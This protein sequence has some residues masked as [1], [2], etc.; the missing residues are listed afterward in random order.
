MDNRL[1]RSDS[2]QPWFPNVG[3]WLIVFGIVL[4]VIA[5]S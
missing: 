5:N 3:K 2:G 4:F 1:P